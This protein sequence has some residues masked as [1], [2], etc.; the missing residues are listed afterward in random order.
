MEFAE[1]SS[2]IWSCAFS[3]LWWSACIEPHL[4]STQNSDDS[5]LTALSRLRPASPVDKLKLDPV[6]LLQASAKHFLEMG[7]PDEDFG[8]SGAVT[9]QVA[10]IFR[11]LNDFL[12]HILHCDSA[13]SSPSD[14]WLANMGDAADEIA[15]DFYATRRP[16]C[17]TCFSVDVVRDQLRASEDVIQAVACILDSSR[18]SELFSRERDEHPYCSMD[19]VCANL[20]MAAAAGKSRP[21]VFEALGEPALLHSAGKLRRALVAVSSLMDSAPLRRLQQLVSRWGHNALQDLPQEL[22]LDVCDAAPLKLQRAMLSYVMSEAGGNLSLQLSSF[23]GQLTQKLNLIC[24]TQGGSDILEFLG[25]ACRSKDDATGQRL[26]VGVLGDCFERLLA[27]PSKRSTHYVSLLGELRRVPDLVDWDAFRQRVVPYLEPGGAEDPA[28]DEF[29]PVRVSMSVRSSM[30]AQHHLHTAQMLIGLL[31]EACTRLNGARKERL[32]DFLDTY[33]SEVLDPGSSFYEDKAIWAATSKDPL[34]F[35]AEMWDD[36]CARLSAEHQGCPL[37]QLTLPYFAQWLAGATWDEWELLLER[38]EAMLRFGE[39]GP[40][41]A[42]DVVKFLTLCLAGCKRFLVVGNW[43]HLFSC[44]AKV[45]TKLLQREE[46]A[47]DEDICAVLVELAFCLCLVPEQCQRQAV[48]LLLD[49][50][51]L[52]DSADLKG[53]LSEPL[54]ATL[55]AQDSSPKTFSGAVDRLVRSFGEKLNFKEC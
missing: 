41:T 19:S 16:E 10:C 48:V 39:D 14:D 17:A 6:S 4:R 18:V 3:A 22:V 2:Y 35:S 25:S 21:N 7:A 30:S 15:E 29:F 51:Q 20:L 9:K 1:D 34:L 38:A 36:E 24:D 46:K 32:L 26:L 11:V 53:R 8:S 37:E 52:L 47:I 31:D 43:C 50:V 49:A 12:S 13:R 42:V 28:P 44:F 54:K 40:V 5:T 27:R 23:Q 55:T 33:L 45:V